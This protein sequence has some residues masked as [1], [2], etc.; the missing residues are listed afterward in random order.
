MYLLRSKIVACKPDIE[1]DRVP[2]VLRHLTDLPR[3]DPEYVTFLNANLL[4][5]S[6]TTTGACN[7]LWMVSLISMLIYFMK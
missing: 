3:L 1:G 6:L 4:E 5:M 7:L 2:K